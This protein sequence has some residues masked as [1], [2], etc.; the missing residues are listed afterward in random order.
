MTQTTVIPPAYVTQSEE[1]YDKPL[2]P[3]VARRLI[4]FIAP[5]KWQMLFAAFFMLG[6]TVSTVAGP[7][8]VKIAIDDGLTAGNPLASAECRAPVSGR[9]HHPLGIHLFPRQHHG[10]HRAVGYL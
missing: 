10:A 2:D 1:L 8:F 9:S 6:S 3:A 5:Y 7:Y 4:G